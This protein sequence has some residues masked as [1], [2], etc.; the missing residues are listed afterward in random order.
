[1]HYTRLMKSY[2]QTP[3]QQPVQQVE[4][5]DDTPSEMVLLLRKMAEQQCQMPKALEESVLDDVEVN[6]IL[7]DALNFQSKYFS[8]I[9]LNRDI[10]KQFLYN[11]PKNVY[12]GAK[13][14]R[15]HPETPDVL[16]PVLL[17]YPFLTKEPADSIGVYLI[18]LSELIDG[19][20]EAIE[21]DALKYIA[22]Q[23]YEEEMEEFEDE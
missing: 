15:N 8:N 18:K 11:V 4:H 23:R 22:D 16:N 13:Y 14:M 9:P 10:L 19:S 3:V 21:D 17:L 20:R 2:V 1:M 12:E 5:V 6:M 7:E